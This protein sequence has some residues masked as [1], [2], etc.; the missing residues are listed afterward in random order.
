MCASTCVILL[1][2]AM[3]TKFTI[4]ISLLSEENV[5]VNQW[6]QVVRCFNQQPLLHATYA[7]IPVISWRHEAASLLRGERF[8]VVSIPC[9]QSCRDGRMF[10][11]AVAERGGRKKKKRQRSRKRGSISSHGRPGKLCGMQLKK[12]WVILHMWLVFQVRQQC[13]YATT[14]HLVSVS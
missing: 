7:L 3:E 11:G 6:F 14:L 13:A 8:A 10:N 2:T 4:Q 9:K 5:R 1:H 12:V